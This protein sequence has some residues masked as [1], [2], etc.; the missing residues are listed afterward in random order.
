MRIVYFAHS[1]LS[2]GGDKMVLVYTN[3]FASSGHHVTI[4]TNVLSTLFTVHPSVHVERLVFPSKIGTIVSALYE[5]HSADCIIASIVPMACF[6]FLRNRTR[7]IYFAQDYDESYY[8]NRVQKYFIRFF[9]FLG[10]T[11]FKIPTIAV[12][13]RLAE[14]L[15]RRFKANVAVVVNGVDT[16]IFY[17]EP[18]RELSEQKGIRKALLLLSRS[19]ARKGFDLAVQ[20]IQALSQRIS[21]P[22]EIWTV[23]E[24]VQSSSF[25]Y[26]HRDFGYVTERELRGL[27]SSCD[28]FLYPSRHEGFPLMVVEA[29]ACK[30]PVVTTEAVPYAINNKNALVS[31]IDDVDSL[32]NNVSILLSD[33]DLANRLTAEGYR[34]ALDHSLSAS[35]DKFEGTLKGIIDR[36]LR[37][38]NIIENVK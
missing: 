21:I 25:P 20:C 4:R 10:L 31:R 36:G 38:G 24:R 1:L 11:V 3:H 23:G 34:F 6:L 32:T 18:S 8:T 14:I 27:L 22:L 17:P 37:S 19:D 28:V 33:A 29:F 7:V 12:S 26:T 13:Q 15:R 30:C 9:Y 16:N 2:R 5:K 35:K